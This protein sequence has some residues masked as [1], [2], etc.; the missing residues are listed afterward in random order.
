MYIVAI[1]SALTIPANFAGSKVIAGTDD[2]DGS[3][4][5]LA[6]ILRLRG[7][8][9]TNLGIISAP[10]PGNYTFTPVGGSTVWTP[11][12]SLDVGDALVLISANVQDPTF[13]DIGIT[14]LAER[15]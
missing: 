7:G 6:T 15:A 10:T 9:Y 4:N 13:A 3:L 11:D 1:A 12:A 14:I 5:S 8:N 2:T